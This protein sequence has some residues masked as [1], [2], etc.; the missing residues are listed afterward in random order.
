MRSWHIFRVFT[1][2]LKEFEQRSAKEAVLLCCFIGGTAKK[3]KLS[4]FRLSNQNAPSDI[5]LWSVM[6]CISLNTSGRKPRNFLLNGLITDF[7]AV[8]Y[9]LSMTEIFYLNVTVKVIMVQRN[10]CSWFLTRIQHK[11]YNIRI[12]NK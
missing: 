10:V 1:R 8:S 5:I 6:M 7:N 2:L 3:E 4:P 12:S 11:N 9:A